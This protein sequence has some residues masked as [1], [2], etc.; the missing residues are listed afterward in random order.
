ML[1]AGLAIARGKEAGTLTTTDS[2]ASSSH[3]LRYTK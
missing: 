3:H 1:D 2:S